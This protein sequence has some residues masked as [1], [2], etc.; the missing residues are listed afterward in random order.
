WSDST[1]WS[2]NQVPNNGSGN[3]FDVVLSAGNIV[4]DLSA[5]TLRNFQ[6]T[7]GAVIS[8]GL[9]AINVTNSLIWSAGTLSNLYAIVAS[10]SMTLSPLPNGGSS[11]LLSRGQLLNYGPA[12]L[13]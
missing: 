6:Q 4:L 11:P 5:V 10:K 9:N 7:G 12:T 1:K 13:T 8:D 2:C 3:R